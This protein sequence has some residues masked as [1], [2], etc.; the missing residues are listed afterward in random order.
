MYLY[1]ESS[2]VETDFINYLRGILQGDTLSLILFALSVNPLS[3]LPQQHEGYKAGKVIRVKNISHLFFVDN[4]KLYTINIEKMKQMLETVTQFLNEVRMNFGEAKCAYQSI[5]RGRQKP[6]NES[7]YVN[8]LT[9]QEIKEGDNYKYLGIDES[10]RIDGPLNKDR[11]RK[12]YKSRVRKIWKSELNGY[13]KMIA[14]NAFAVALVTPSIGIL[15][16]TKKEI[17]DLD[18]ITRKILTMTSSFHRAGDTDRLYAHRS[19]GGR[20]LRSME[21]LYEIRMVG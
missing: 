9:L 4:L 3:H 5:V 8:E 2:N 16:W 10:V 11:I 17:S 21:D 14:H 20:G 7:L 6:E 18:V 19:K 13:N 15:K 1:G 12:E